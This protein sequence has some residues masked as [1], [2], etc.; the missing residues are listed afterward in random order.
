M[1]SENLAIRSLRSLP[2]MSTAYVTRQRME[3]I[4]WLNPWDH[5]MKRIVGVSGV[6]PCLNANSGGVAGQTVSATP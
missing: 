5:Q 2:H 1:A 6:Y 3:E 4:E